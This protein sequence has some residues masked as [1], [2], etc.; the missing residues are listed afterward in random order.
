MGLGFRTFL[1]MGQVAD[2]MTNVFMTDYEVVPLPFVM[3][4]LFWSMG[5]YLSENIWSLILFSV[6]VLCYGWSLT[7]AKKRRGARGHE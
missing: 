7:Y 2:E 3:F 1:L 6:S 5:A 4:I